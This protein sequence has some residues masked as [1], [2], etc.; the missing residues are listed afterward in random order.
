[1]KFEFEKFMKDLDK[2]NLLKVS[3]Q[4]KL[5]QDEEAWYTRKLY[6]QSREHPMNNR[7]YG[8]QKDEA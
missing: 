7:V 8:R 3:R 4:E 2:K 5:Q 6:Q 1:M